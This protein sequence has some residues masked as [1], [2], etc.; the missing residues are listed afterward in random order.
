MG[1]GGA[2][3]KGAERKG[4]GE[5]TNRDC[6]WNPFTLLPEASVTTTQPPH[7]IIPQTSVERNSGYSG[8]FA[9]IAVQCL[10]RDKLSA[11][12][13]VIQFLKESRCNCTVLSQHTNGGNITR[14]TSHV[15][16]GT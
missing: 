9:C 4:A 14:L 3:R 13:T 15:Y 10:G 7:L 5:A 2:E 8:N 1:G 12:R 6:S 16:Q 11:R